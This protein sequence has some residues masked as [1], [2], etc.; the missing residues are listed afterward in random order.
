MYYTKEGVIMAKILVISAHPHME[1]SLMNKTILEELTQSS[2]D[3]SIRDIA[4][5]CC[6]VD[7]AEAQAALKEAETI[8]FQFPVYWFNAPALLKHWYE[9]VFTPGFAHGEGAEG[10]KG[11]KLVLSATIGAPEAAYSA[12]GLGHSMSDFFANF[13]AMAAMTG[14]K[15]GT[16]VLSYGCMYIPGVSTEADKEALIAKA[17]D[18]AKKLVEEIG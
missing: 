12:Q 10:L 4:A 9:E 5:D 8:V 11:K 1:R 18:H 16:P 2:L 6:H 17:K 7:V 14:M 13:G 15:M 3:L